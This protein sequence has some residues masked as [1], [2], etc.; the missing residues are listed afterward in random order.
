[1]KKQEILE[2]CIAEVRSGKSTVEDC[3]QRYPEL[4]EELSHLLTIATNISAEDATPSDEFKRRAKR[5][6]FEKMEESTAKASWRYVFWPRAAVSRVI[7]STLAGL[8]IVG[9][10]GSSVVY[11]SQS[12]LPGD[13]LY[14]VKTGAEEV[15]LAL[16]FDPVSKANLHL[17]FAQRRVNEVT[18]QIALARNI[19][20]EALSAVTR[21]Y[22]QAI[23]DLS[24]SNN[25]TAV[26]SVLSRMSANSLEQQLE[27]QQSITS[28]PQA[29]QQ[30]LQ[31]ALND[32]RRGSAI[33][34]VGYANNDY[35]KSQ[36]SVTDK[37][38]DDGPFSMEG[39][40]QVVGEGIWNIG[41]T[42]VENIVY[43]GK[44][45]LAGSVVT[46]KGFVK[47]NKVYISS[48]TAQESTTNAPEASTKLE[49]KY[50]GINKDGTSNVGGIPVRIG[51]NN[52]QIQPG[53][54]VQL[55]D[56]TANQQWAIPDYRP[57]KNYGYR[58]FRNRNK[59]NPFSD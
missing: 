54:K 9:A 35:I 53:D 7:V 27:L 31:Q 47:N 59:R 19:D 40:L 24:E 39:S 45:P 10:A 33:A 30:A 13:T 3:L 48:I 23:T 43:R 44:V 56:D 55:Q 38:I 34:E 21:Q 6:L 11:A 8:I 51:G 29:N 20:Q 17:E 46:V 22:D 5:Y 41:G 52:P 14:P 42:Q 36:P 37:T 26:N 2:N 12:S 4:C 49:G 15:Q 50:N 18:S 58:R 32:T 28:A 57:R 16:T 25:K 1:M